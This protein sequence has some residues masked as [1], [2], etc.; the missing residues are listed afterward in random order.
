[1]PASIE[2]RAPAEMPYRGCELYTYLE[3]SAEFGGGGVYTVSNS[4]PYITSLLHFGAGE[5]EPVTLRPPPIDGITVITAGQLCRSFCTALPV[6]ER[7]DDSFAK[8]IHQKSR[9]LYD[10]DKEENNLSGL[11]QSGNADSSDSGSD[12][13]DG[14]EYDDDIYGY[15]DDYEYERSVNML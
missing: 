14:F 11:G 1:M 7:F 13:E 4:A 3:G 2:F 10:V 8:L 15:F 9:Q 6:V 12:I 5:S